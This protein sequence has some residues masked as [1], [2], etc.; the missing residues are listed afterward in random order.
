MEKDEPPKFDPDGRDPA[1]VETF[2]WLAEC[3]G[4]PFD[5]EAVPTGKTDPEWWRETR[6]AIE[7]SPLSSGAAQIERNALRPD[8]DL[9]LS[10]KWMRDKALKSYLQQKR[11]PELWT[12]EFVRFIRSLIQ[13]KRP[14]DGNG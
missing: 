12:D 2:R 3:T 8:Y 4:T 9:T 10:Q 14:G 11:D 13:P 6:A 1:L 7:A 5:R